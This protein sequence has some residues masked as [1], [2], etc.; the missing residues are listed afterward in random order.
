MRVPNTELVSNASS[1]N[2]ILL[3]HGV[4]VRNNTHAQVLIYILAIAQ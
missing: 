4:T 2:P 3:P 1:S